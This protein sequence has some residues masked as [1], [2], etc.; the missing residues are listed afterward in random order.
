MNNKYSRICIYVLGLI[1]ALA[2]LGK[3]VFADFNILEPEVGSNITIEDLQQI[4]V[5]QTSI[6]TSAGY[7]ITAQIIIWNGTTP[8]YWNGNEF[9]STE[10]NVTYQDI[11]EEVSYEIWQ[12]QNGT[13]STQKVIEKLGP[14][15]NYTIT[16]KLWNGTAFEEFNY[17]GLGDA[18]A[19][20]VYLYINGDLK[21]NQT[22]IITQE[23][24]NI[25]IKAEVEDKAPTLG[26]EANFTVAYENGTTI[27]EA[28]LTWSSNS[29]SDQT[30]STEY[31][32]SLEP[33]TNYTIELKAIDNVGNEN[34]T[35]AKIIY[36]PLAPR[37]NEFVVSP[38]GYVDANTTPIKVKWNITDANFANVT[39]YVRLP[40][41]TVVNKKY[42]ENV[43]EIAD[44][45]NELNI[46]KEIEGEY[47]VWIETCDIVGNCN[48]STKYTFIND[49]YKPFIKYY[50]EVQ[51]EVNNLVVKVY[52]RDN[53]SENI[54]VVVELLTGNQIVNETKM[55]LQ[56]DT[57][58]VLT[59][60]LDPKKKY[61]LIVKGYDQV[62]HWKEGE[63]DNGQP[64]INV[65]DGVYYKDS[66]TVEVTDDT[67]VKE[68]LLN[69]NSMNSIFTINETGEY[70]VKACDVFDRCLERTF[71]VDTE[72]PKVNITI[73]NNTQVNDLLIV[74][75]D[76]VFWVDVQDDISP[77]INITVYVNGTPECTE[78]VVNG[79]KNY[80][81]IV[82]L[83]E[84]VYNITINASDLAGHKINVWEGRIQ[85]LEGPSF[86]S[87][88]TA[89]IEV[90]NI[91]TKG[92]NVTVVFKVI[93]EDEHGDKTVRIVG[94]RESDTLNCVQE[95][96][97]EICTAVF[98]GVPI[99][100]YTINITVDDNGIQSVTETVTVNYTPQLEV[101]TSVTPVVLAKDEPVD[102][103]VLVTD[104]Y[105]TPVN[106]AEV[107]LNDTLGNNPM[108]S[109]TNVDGRVTFTWDYPEVAEGILKVCY[110]G[111]CEE[112][113]VWVADEVKE[114]SRGWNI[115]G[116]T[117]EVDEA[118]VWAKVKE[119]YNVSN[120]T[121]LFEHRLKLIGKVEET[122]EL[123]RGR[124]YI[125][126]VK[127]R[128]R[129]PLYHTEG[130]DVGVETLILPA[131]WSLLTVLRNANNEPL[132][133][134]FD[135]SVS[136][137][138]VDEFVS[139]IIIWNPTTVKHDIRVM[140]NTALSRQVTV[141]KGDLLLVRILQPVEVSL[142]TA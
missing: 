65:T 14:I 63:K 50:Y 60:E 81:I 92:A 16:L 87:N 1:S 118:K 120:L 68:V 91:T 37:I 56:N 46:S 115:F 27:Y 80:K 40:N 66:V 140:D 99:G 138:Y 30:N 96:C 29:T 98:V 15:T 13:L 142:R 33:E 119:I 17:T 123:N 43:K 49:V 11:R 86:E 28:T 73:Q 135:V 25:T 47:E 133:Q 129:I 137:D 126:Y 31:V 53:Q 54:T 93:D 113:K 88:V 41:G 125:Y 112:I 45:F 128:V 122:E 42:N 100:T 77:T 70:T 97:N 58:E 35:T 4:K 108:T 22:V 6:T 132:Y 107:I 136:D 116:I 117:E 130:Y 2:F 71:Y 101:E 32:L 79:A 44:L 141:D 76:L 18:G 8:L 9:I 94:L 74:P 102:I 51:N 105:G 114:L 111:V 85:V 82:D 52:A 127:D 7:N 38:I 12:L 83:S 61:K 104:E 90:I 57:I 106:G 34:T 5:K 67:K 55:I 26:G 3:G 139:R 103:Y 21:N 110:G 89:R 24:S 72:A 10:T 62:G 131:G 20:E 23:T 19:P 48:T 109:P 121:E 39:L 84:G 36:D 134:V 69:G 95:G 124:A 75:E 78:T 64:T 59:F